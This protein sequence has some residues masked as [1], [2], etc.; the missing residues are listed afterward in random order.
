MLAL[1]GCLSRSSKLRGIASC[2]P[3][4]LGIGADDYLRFALLRPTTLLSNKASPARRRQPKYVSEIRTFLASLILF[5][6]ASPAKA[7]IQ[8]G[9]GILV[10]SGGFGVDLDA[11]T[12]RF[13]AYGRYEVSA[14]AAAGQ[15]GVKLYIIGRRGSGFYAAASRVD[16]KCHT[17]ETGNLNAKCDDKFRGLWGFLGGVEAPLGVESSVFIDVGPYVGP[18]EPRKI[19]NRSFIFGIRIR[20]PI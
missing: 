16:L 19:R 3:S 17:T 1:A 15:I 10:G 7:Q 12:A 14:H 6:C 20:P 11:A 13:G 9:V 4:I 8:P 2:R 5:I 18:D